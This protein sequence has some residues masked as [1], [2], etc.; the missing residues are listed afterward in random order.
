MVIKGGEKRM[1]GQKMTRKR[2]KNIGFLLNLF[3][4]KVL[5]LAAFLFPLI[6]IVNVNAGVDLFV[7]SAGTD[8]VLRYKG[9]TVL[10]SMHSSQQ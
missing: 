3:N 5:A 9:T 10:S 4:L 8:E 1:D 2:F 7:V 6:G